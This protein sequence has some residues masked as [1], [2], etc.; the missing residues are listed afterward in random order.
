MVKIGAWRTRRGASAT[1]TA[2]ISRIPLRSGRAHSA[3]PAA[4]CA[5]ARFRDVKDAS[6]GRGFRMRTA[7]FD[8]DT[9]SFAAVGSR[10]VAGMRYTPHCTAQDYTEPHILGSV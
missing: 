8:G 1:R 4:T 7:F 5:I 2:I 10:H 9:N 3:R 6:P